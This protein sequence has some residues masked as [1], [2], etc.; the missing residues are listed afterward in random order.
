[1]LISYHLVGTCFAAA[2]QGWDGAPFCGCGNWGLGKGSDGPR[3]IQLQCSRVRIWIWPLSPCT[4]FGRNNK[5]TNYETWVV[6]LVHSG[7]MVST[8]EWMNPP[9]CPWVSYITQ[10]HTHSHTLPVCPHTQTPALV[11]SYSIRSFLFPSWPRY[12][13]AL[14]LL[15][16]R[17]IFM[18]PELG[19][20]SNLQF[21]MSLWSKL[22][23]LGV[24]FPGLPCQRHL[25]ASLTYRLA[26]CILIRSPGES[27]A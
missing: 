9:V 3:A 27:Y 14:W 17:F 23:L 5:T 20:P 7:C 18:K 11:S 2:L 15:E 22:S 19:L 12:A 6:N 13:F 24:G 4:F 8:V 26:I 16:W 1:M 21:L 25:G 10:S